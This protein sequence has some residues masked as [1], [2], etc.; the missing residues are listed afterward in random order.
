MRP[1]VF[2]APVLLFAFS[3]SAQ[4]F[5]RPGGG[6]APAA[7]ESDVPECVSLRAE[8]RQDGVGFMHVVIVQNRCRAVVRC[9][10]STDADPTPEHPVVVSPG[11]EAEVVTHTGSPVPGFRPRA[12]CRE[13]GAR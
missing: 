11:Q 13:D 12:V 7:P 3:V 5:P 10:V 6:T 4:I 8:P 9:R 2:A 1:I